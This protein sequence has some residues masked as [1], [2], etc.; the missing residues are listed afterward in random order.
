MNTN[1]LDKKSVVLIMNSV[2]MS[3]LAESS[4]AMSV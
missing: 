2:L 3:G 4:L 1:T